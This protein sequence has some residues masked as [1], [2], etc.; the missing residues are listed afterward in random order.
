MSRSDSGQTLVEFALS[1][2]VLLL[3]IFGLIEGGR[4]LHGWITLQS[5]AREGGRYA[6]TGQ[7]EEECL[8]HTPACA[9]A[10]VWS[11]ER[12]V[13]DSATGLSIDPRAGYNDPKYLRVD[14]SAV[15]KD[16]V[17]RSD[18]SGLPGRPVMVRAVYRIPLIT[19]I[20]R[21]IAKSVKLTGQVVVNNENYAQVNRSSI[22]IDIG[23]LPPP[24]PPLVPVADLEIEASAS[25][26]V[27]LIN[28]PITFALQITNNG[29]DEARGVEVVDTLPANVTLLSVSPEGICDQSGQV[30]TCQLPSLPRGVEYDIQLTVRAPAE[31]PPA[32]GTVVNQVTVTGAEQDD[33]LSN[34]ED[35]TET[36]VVLSEEV[37][38]MAIINIDDIPDPVVVNRELTYTVLVRNNGISDASDIEVSGDLPDGFTFV[39]GSVSSGSGCSGSNAT[40]R[41]QIDA[42]ASGETAWAAITARA[43]D[44][45]DSATFVARVSAAQVDPDERN[46]G[47]SEVTTI[48]PEWSD[49][50]VS[51]EDRPDPALVGEEITYSIIAGNNG[52]SVARDVT[53]VDNLPD[54]V[55]FVSSSGPAGSCDTVDNQV[56]CDVGVILRNQEVLIEVVVR[57]REAGTLTNQAE[58]SG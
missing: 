58:I 34:N 10:R 16:N 4:L 54:S 43:P 1:L 17:W 32:P 38:D 37:A 18:Y 36:L 14:V 15:D 7:F 55:D 24:P 11:I 20:I 28:E 26:L 42:V 8:S 40:A 48:S 27:S 2:T 53:V 51:I 49:L 19:P 52:P 9:D 41:C 31:P 13:L 47:S 25:P 50:Y 5:A 12:R 56:T 46:N 39:S 44:S 57:P 45:P 30:L 3:L 22:D 33:D 29:P 23:D 6:I 21:P 35:S